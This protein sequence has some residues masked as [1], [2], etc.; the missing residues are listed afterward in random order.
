MKLRVLIS[1]HRELE[2]ELRYAME[3]ELPVRTRVQTPYG[4]GYVA[5]YK[6]HTAVVTIDPEGMDD[7][8]GHNEEVELAD[9]DPIVQE[10]F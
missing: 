8:I 10:R 7:W 5:Y 6:G 2:Q 9:I 3:K 4:P 1:T